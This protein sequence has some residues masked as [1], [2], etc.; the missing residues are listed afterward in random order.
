MR[1]KPITI[2]TIGSV[3]KG[4]SIW[5][6]QQGLSKPMKEGEAATIQAEEV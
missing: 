5:D 1:T 6:E 2:D 4:R 3:L